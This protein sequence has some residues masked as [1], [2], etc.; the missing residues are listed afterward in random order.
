MR[1][2]PGQLWLTGAALRE[3]LARAASPPVAYPARA[4]VAAMR[5]AARPGGGVV[6]GGVQLPRSGRLSTRG[7]SLHPLCRALMRPMVSF[8]TDVLGRR[9]CGTNHA[10]AESN[11]G[12]CDHQTIA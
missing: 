2:G 12:G 9:S 3:A 11:S 7:L 5:E 8:T 4:P 6:I 10:N 1:R